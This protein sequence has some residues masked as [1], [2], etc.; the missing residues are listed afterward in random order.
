M[1]P[2]STGLRRQA[3]QRR[4]Y[5]PHQQVENEVWSN[6]T[7][8]LALLVLSVYALMSAVAFA[9][10]ATDKRRAVGAKLRISELTLHVVALLGGWPGAF[11]AQRVFRHKWRKGSF[12]TWFWTIVA[13]HAGGWVWWL[14]LSE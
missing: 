2:P 6:S 9:L 10:Y 5:R 8:R 13:V 4:H 12:M 1:L 14:T 11:V 7:M 3:F